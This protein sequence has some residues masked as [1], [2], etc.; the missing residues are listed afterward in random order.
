M[1]MKKE[2][3]SCRLACYVCHNDAFFWCVECSRNYC[4]LCW[5]SIGHH[6]Y[7]DPDE[8]WNNRKPENVIEYNPNDEVGMNVF[9]R[10][11]EICQGRVRGVHTPITGARPKSPGLQSFNFPPPGGVPADSTAGGSRGSNLQH[12]GKHRGKL[13]E[14]GILRGNA[15]RQSGDDMHG[16]VV[17][18][19]K[20]RPPPGMSPLNSPAN[21]VSHP[22]SPA[23]STGQQTPNDSLSIHSPDNSTQQP[24]S[25]VNKTV[26]H[27]T[28]NRTQH[29]IFIMDPVPNQKLMWQVNSSGHSLCPVSSLVPGKYT[30]PARGITSEYFP[31]DWKQGRA[32]VHRQFD[33]YNGVTV[34]TR[35]IPEK[36]PTPKSLDLQVGSSVTLDKKSKLSSRK[37]TDSIDSVPMLDAL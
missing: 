30:R 26:T 34:A 33:I 2:E 31:Q 18:P 25:P 36:E 32:N 27:D 15:P 22:P 17:S 1:V 8:V 4:K 28:Q 11:N 21:K 12:R 20:H 35:K 37:S 24:F 10:P 5:N 19:P 6:E 9:L 16:L 7:I 13:L 3:I 14:R 23:R 29:E